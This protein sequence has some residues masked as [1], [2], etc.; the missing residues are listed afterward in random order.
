MG[1]CQTS[2]HSNIYITALWGHYSLHTHCRELQCSLPEAPA[3]PLSVGGTTAGAV[4]AEKVR[5][6]ET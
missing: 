3:P 4:H 2:Q 5:E 6:S 1:A